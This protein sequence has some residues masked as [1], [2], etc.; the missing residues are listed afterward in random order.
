MKRALGAHQSGRVDEAARLYRQVILQDPKDDVAL[1]NLGLIASARH[2]YPTA[3]SMMDASIKLKPSLAFYRS[4]Y[5]TVLRAMG[6]TKLS[7]AEAD[8][9]IGLDPRFAAAWNNKALAHMDLG[10]DDLAE[11]AF[12]KAIALD[13]A[14]ADAMTNFAMLRLRQGRYEEGE[15]FAVKALRTKPGHIRALLALGDSYVG[16]QRFAGG[17]AAYRR[18]IETSPNNVDAFIRLGRA[19]SE[20]GDSDG[21]RS[22]LEHAVSLAPDAPATHYELGM[23]LRRQGAMDEASASLREAI[24]L[25]PSFF[26]AYASL[27]RTV[28]FDSVEVPEFQAMVQAY[29]AVP[30]GSP[31]RGYL[32]YGLGE[33]FEGIGEHRQAFEKFQ[34]GNRIRRAEVEYSEA[35]QIARLEAIKTVFTP[36]FLDRFNGKGNASRAPIFILGM[37]RSGTTL[38]EQIVSVSEEVYGA[39][40]LFLV[41]AASNNTFGFATFNETI[42]YLEKVD[43]LDFSKAGS[44]YLEWLSEKAKAKPRF[45]DKLPHNFWQIGTIRLMFPNAKIVH[46]NRSPIDTCLSMYKTSFGSPGLNYSYDLGE[47]GRYFNLYRGVMRHWRHVLPAAFFELTYESLVERPEEETRRLFDYLGL[48]WNPAVLEFH[49]TKRDVKTASVAQ[50]R[51]PIYKTSV[52]LSERYGELLDPLRAALGEWKDDESSAS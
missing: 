49:R 30:P 11:Q 18:A 24:R 6:R 35:D 41:N 43:T 1:H 34:E 27:A 4:N 29:S 25:N 13:P 31:A 21:A 19:L 47:L 42:R 28:R 8:V 23:Q 37:P 32:A 39:G 36:A 2:D 15:V 12:K 40:E 44:T 14:Y 3:Q 45:T 50:V 9:A 20:V 22:Q 7:I 16:K 51:R 52:N 5:S 38:T 48:R 10:Q 33:A 26:A 46:L 17:I